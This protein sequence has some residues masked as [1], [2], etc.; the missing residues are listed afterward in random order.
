ML[1]LALNVCSATMI[2]K[3]DFLFDVNV[4]SGGSF[5]IFFILFGSWLY[6][7]FC[8]M[9]LMGIIYCRKFF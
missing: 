5:Y 2:L 7:T 6:I 9:H 8:G 4:D 1:C 3:I